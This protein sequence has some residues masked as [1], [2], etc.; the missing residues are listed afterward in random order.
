MWMVLVD[1][2]YAAG[3]LVENTGSAAV[4]RMV[5]GAESLVQP[6][7]HAIRDSPATDMAFGLTTVKPVLGAVVARYSAQI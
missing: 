3:L 1:L 6:R 2:G 7:V 4:G 5:A